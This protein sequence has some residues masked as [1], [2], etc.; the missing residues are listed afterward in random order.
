[1]TEPLILCGELIVSEDGSVVI[2]AEELASA[3]YD[4]CHG[5]ADHVRIV[6]EEVEEE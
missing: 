4:W 5:R 2:G 6:L 3:I 1:M